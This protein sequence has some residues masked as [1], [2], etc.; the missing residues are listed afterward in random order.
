MGSLYSDSIGTVM[1]LYEL[2]FGA[3]L[4]LGPGMGGILYQIGGFYLP[5]AVT[6]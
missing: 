6:G 4:A 3:A 5:F 2:A 1:A